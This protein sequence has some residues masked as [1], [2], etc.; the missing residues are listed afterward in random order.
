M[1]IP[2]WA[3]TVLVFLESK[4]FAM[5]FTTVITGAWNAFATRITTFL[6][7]VIGTIIIFVLGWIVGSIDEDDGGEDSKYGAI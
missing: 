7:L 1:G 3:G 2:H 5:E 6:P 4:E